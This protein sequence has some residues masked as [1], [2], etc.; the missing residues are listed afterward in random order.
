[1]MPFIYGWVFPVSQ[2][3]KFSSDLIEDNKFRLKETIFFPMMMPRVT[4]YSGTR[5]FYDS[6]ERAVRQG[7]PVFI[8]T[9]KRMGQY[10]E[11]IGITLEMNKIGPLSC[12]N[13]LGVAST[14]PVGKVV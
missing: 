8:F 9:R 7:E 1:R 5:I 4:V 2:K 3:A 12:G 6:S 13:R 11:C 14:L 10:S